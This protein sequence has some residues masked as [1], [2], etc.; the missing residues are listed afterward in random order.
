MK[1]LYWIPGIAFALLVIVV[2]MYKMAIGKALECEVSLYE[3]RYSVDNEND[4]LELIRVPGYLEL[5]RERSLLNSQLQLAKND[6]IGLFLGLRDSV[7]ELVVKGVA[8]TRFSLKEIG[9]SPL[10]SRL[11][12][13]SRYELLSEPWVITEA[14]STISREPLNVI[15][16]PKDTSEIIPFVVPD[17]THS[18]PVFFTLSTDKGVDL[19]FYQVDSKTKEDKVRERAIARREAREQYRAFMYYI[20]GGKAMTYKPVIRIGMNKVDAKVLYRALP[21]RG[22]VAVS[23]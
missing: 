18:E 14:M 3:G 8:V 11:S 7:A 4:T 17:T 9:V 16:A 13:E 23:F 20:L 6:S 12:P 2:I 1:K 10:F 19:C 21:S 22:L 15:Q 5:L